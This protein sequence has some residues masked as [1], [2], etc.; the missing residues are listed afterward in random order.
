MKF[1]IL[2]VFVLLLYSCSNKIIVHTDFDKSIEIHR[3]T[4]YTWLQKT[5]TESLNNPLYYNELNDKRIKAAVDERLKDKGYQQSDSLSKLIV[6]YHLA[7]NDKVVLNT[8]PY[9]YKYSSLWTARGLDTFR[10][11]EGTLIIDFMDPENH[12]L[13]WRGWAVSVLDDN[14]L[15]TEELINKAVEQIFKTFPP[16]TIKE[17][18]EL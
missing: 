8:A 16:S 13:I 3:L 12:E 17:V 5:H 15:I 14:D 4:T 6:H 18:K 11:R 10:Y 7:I 9:G 1:L 2:S